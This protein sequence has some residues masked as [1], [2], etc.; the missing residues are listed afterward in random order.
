MG[1]EAAAEVEL[2]LVEAIETLFYHWNYQIELVELV[3]DHLA[4]LKQ[5]NVGQTKFQWLVHALPLKFWNQDQ[6]QIDY[7]LEKENEL[8]QL[9]R[10]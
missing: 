5:W 10:R 9:S 6:H 1:E 4:Y 3:T 2:E 8:N 7:C